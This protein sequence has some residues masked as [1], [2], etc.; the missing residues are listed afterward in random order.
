M[1]RR[2]DP[3]RLAVWRAL[4]GA[5]AAIVGR[6]EHELHEQRGL[7]LGWYD[8]L[9]Q[10]NEAGGALRMHELARRLLVNKSSLTRV[11]DRMEECGYIE[12]RRV[13]DDARGVEAAITPHGRTE[14]RAAAPVH[15]RGVQQHFARHLTETDV[16]A[17]QRV[18]AKLPGAEPREPS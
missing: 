5:H 10:L 9:L 15:L 11:C 7:P 14:L 12:R 3:E 8:V 2:P 6:L 13:P 17:L 4:L 16:A 1:A 18:F